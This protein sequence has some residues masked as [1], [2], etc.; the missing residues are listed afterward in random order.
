MQGGRPDVQRAVAPREDATAQFEAVHVFGE[1]ARGGNEARRG[2][3]PAALRQNRDPVN[4]LTCENAVLP[5]FAG[6]K[7]QSLVAGLVL[8][9][10]LKTGADH[11]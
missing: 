5:Y 6:M 1:S 7:S 9:A 4:R 11:G 2:S 8:A 10:C 3:F